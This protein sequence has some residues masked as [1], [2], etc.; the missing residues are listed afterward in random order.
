MYFQ[1]LKSQTQVLSSVSYF[2][3][4]LKHVYEPSHCQVGSLVLLQSPACM[5]V[6]KRPWQILCHQHT[7][8]TFFISIINYGERLKEHSGSEG[9]EYLYTR[10]A[11]GVDK[12]GEHT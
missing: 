11:S 9:F 2:Q 10:T 4:E 3:A 7:S 6:V 12:S 5:Q 1:E 8:V